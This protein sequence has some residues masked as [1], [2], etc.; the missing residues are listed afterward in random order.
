MVYHRAIEYSSLETASFQLSTFWITS[1]WVS[2]RATGPRE[3]QALLSHPALFITGLLRPSSEPS[4]SPRVLMIRKEQ[5]RKRKQSP[6]GW[7]G[8]RTTILQQRQI[9]LDP[10]IK[11]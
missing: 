3:Q 10:D 8:T 11:R 2:L 5:R 4:E 1:V 6:L 7:K 9:R